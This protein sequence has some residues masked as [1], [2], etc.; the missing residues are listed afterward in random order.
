MEDR[1]VTR[2]KHALEGACML[3]LAKKEL[4]DITVTELCKTAGVDRKTFYHHYKSIA[5]IPEAIEKKFLDDMQHLFDHAQR[6]LDIPC[7]FKQLL[8]CLEQG[9]H[10]PEVLFSRSAAEQLSLHLESTMIDLLRDRFLSETKLDPI[11]F[12]VRARYIT[13]GV[14]A[15]YLQWFRAGKPISREELSQKMGELVERECRQLL[16]P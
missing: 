3:L 5:D 2:T 12:T 8:Q 7:L 15:V 10:Y 1:R 9:I 11:S 4:N 13:G 16:N 6:P 14:V